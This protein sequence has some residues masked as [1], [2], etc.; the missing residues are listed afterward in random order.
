LLLLKQQGQIKNKS[1]MK[2]LTIYAILITLLFT[3][4]DVV[5]Q[6]V[7][8][9]EEEAPLTEQ[10]VVNGLKEALRISTDT[11]V[12]VVSAL[13]GFYGDQ[14]IRINL[15]PEAEIITKNKD[16]ALLKAVGI[17][18]L[19]DDAIL[20]MNRSAENAAKTATP[21]FVNAI[22]NMTIKDAFNIL[23]GSD[24]A[25][26]HYFRQKTYTQLKNSFKPKISSSLKKPLVGNVSADKAWTS[27]TG[28][29]NDV[30]TFTGW[31]KVNTQL[32]EYVTRKALNGLF[33]KLKAEE[34]QIRKDPK[35]RVTEIL[36]R[37]FG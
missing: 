9:I 7:K 24:T 27:L 1:A 21:I 23:N 35:A 26:T 22:Q 6:V 5:D 3:S 14:L 34:K 2:N 25:A 31:K 12:N 15:P 17:S 33:I 10:E 11:A 13:N 16:N 37:V 18:K 30:A 8:V 19:I 29:Y 36:R 20:R 32:D 4:C 28:A